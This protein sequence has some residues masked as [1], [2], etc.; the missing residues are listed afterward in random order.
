[1]SEV[2]DK[3][4]FHPIH[5]TL[6]HTKITDF[7]Y[8]HPFFVSILL[9]LSSDRPL[10]KPRASPFHVPHYPSS[11]IVPQQSPYY[12]DAQHFPI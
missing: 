5:H 9:G 4:V 12:K 8:S 6:T 1:M 11:H 10:I 3:S 7:F 2:V